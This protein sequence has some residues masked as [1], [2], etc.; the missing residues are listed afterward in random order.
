MLSLKRLLQRIDPGWLVVVAIAVIALWPFVGRASLPQETDAELHVFRLMELTYLVR[1]GELYPRWAPNF[2]HGY[3]YPIFNY[4]APLAYY[5]G[6][7]LTLLPAFDA[8]A[9]VKAVFVL[10][11]LLAAV[12]TYGF[13][14]DNWG[15]AAGYVATAVYLYTPYVQFIDPHARGVLAES[16]ALG[17]FPVALWRLDAWRRVGGGW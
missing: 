8:V 13:V 2:Y 7:P 15:R 12:G 4:Y 17:L 3:G 9:G 1:H 14:R 16:L 10:S 6:L 5:A 11:L